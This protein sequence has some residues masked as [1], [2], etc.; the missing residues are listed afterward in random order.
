MVDK[1]KMVL[2]WMQ[3]TIKWFYPG[4][5]IQ[6]ELPNDIVGEVLGIATIELC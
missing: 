6:Y 1:L 5:N 4:C 3:H 2:T